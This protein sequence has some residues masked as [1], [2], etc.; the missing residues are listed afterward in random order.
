LPRAIEASAVERLLAS[1]D[2]RRGIG[3]RDYAILM[4]LSRLGL[5]GGEVVALELEDIDWRGGQILVRGKGRRRDRLP[6]SAEVGEALAAYLRRGRPA[7]TD[8][9]VFLRHFAPHVGLEGS[10]AIRGVLARACCRAGL[11]YANPH[12]LRH[13]VAT[14]MLA[15]GAS[16][17]EIGLVLRQSG[18]T[19]TATYAKVDHARLSALALAWP[20]V[21]P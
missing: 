18:T 13:T 9:R 20:E 14:G 4:L 7:S 11:D 17:S 10:G 5:R 1:C 15:G 12:R 19:T 21:R 2:R 6:L 16:L 3:R 8:R